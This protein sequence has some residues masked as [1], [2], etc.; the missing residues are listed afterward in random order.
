MQIDLQAQSRAHRLGQSRAVLVVRLQTAGSVEERVAAAAAAKRQVA[1]TSI[2]GAPPP[3][4]K[5]MIM[6][7]NIPH[8]P[9]VYGADTDLPISWCTRAALLTWPGSW[10]QPSDQFAEL[11][12]LLISLVLLELLALLFASSTCVLFRLQSSWSLLRYVHH[13]Y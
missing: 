10:H 7:R 9:A 5:I 2:T 6:H 13:T 12:A 1:D 3:G 11:L 4:R 8:S